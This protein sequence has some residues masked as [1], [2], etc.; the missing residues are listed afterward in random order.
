MEK[1]FA[2]V[3]VCFLLCLFLGLWHVVVLASQV[4][5]FGDAM[6]QV[7]KGEGALAVAF[8]DA[9]ETIS[10]AFVH[11]ADSYFH[12]G[13]DMECKHLGSMAVTTMKTATTATA[14]KVVT[15]STTMVKGRMAPLI[16]GVGSTRMSA[17][18]RCIDILAAARQSR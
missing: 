7:V 2:N 11:K 6:P 13:V 16:H 1:F 12:G 8:G 10:R 14:M 17:R 3:R 4:S 5:R 9:R 15:T 18:Q